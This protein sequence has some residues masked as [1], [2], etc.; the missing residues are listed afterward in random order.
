MQ[1]RQVEALTKKK[2]DGTPYTRRV[3][4]ET[5]LASLVNLSRDEMLERLKVRH[6]TSPNYVQSECLVYLIRAARND[7]DERYFNKLY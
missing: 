6:P 7:N 1:K 3:E 4:V 2:Q 5:A